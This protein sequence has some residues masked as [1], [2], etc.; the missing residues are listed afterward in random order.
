MYQTSNVVTSLLVSDVEFVNYT[1]AYDS[2]ENTGTKSLGPYGEGQENI[3]EANSY[4]VTKDIFF[5]Q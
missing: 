4:F 2:T 5:F 1:Y 3:C